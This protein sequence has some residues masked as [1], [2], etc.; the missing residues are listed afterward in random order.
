VRFASRRNR[1]A[2][3]VDA[4]QADDGLDNANWQLLREI[5]IA[6]HQGD[7]EGHV[8][9]LLR[10]ERD[11][12]ADAKAGAYLWYLLRYRVAALLGRRPRPEDLHELA[13]RYAPKFAKLVRG[14]QGELEDTLLT[15]FDF[16]T[17]GRK[18]KGGKAI[19]VG[20]AALGVLLDD[21]EVELAEMRP[22]LADWW[23]RNAMN[24]A[25]SKP[26]T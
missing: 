5:L 18:V 12:P 21:V 26:E 20:S 13:Q 24:F 14:G 25:I 9:A 11:V 3:A 2:N 10:L 19:V 1:S 6:A 7:A 8:A 17:L 22:H 4:N 23:K 15:V 16:T